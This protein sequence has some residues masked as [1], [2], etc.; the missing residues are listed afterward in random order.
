MTVSNDPSSK[1]FHLETA[2]I[3]DREALK[4]STFLSYEQ[5]FVKF[6]FFLPH[7]LNQIT[8]YEKTS[9]CDR[10]RFADHHRV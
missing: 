2:F 9:F 4:L 5:L 10:G 1:Y 8:F 7:T 6:I 3:P